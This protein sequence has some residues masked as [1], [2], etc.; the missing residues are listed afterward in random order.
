LLLSGQHLIDK[1]IGVLRK[2]LELLRERNLKETSFEEK[3]ELVARLGI[4]I[5]PSE[6]LKSRRISCQL[7]LQRTQNER[8]QS[9]SAKVVY[10]SAYRICNPTCYVIFL[11]SNW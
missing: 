6:D 1:D 10:G 9:D 4:K 7:N 3:E 2:E 5:Y 8:K 11:R